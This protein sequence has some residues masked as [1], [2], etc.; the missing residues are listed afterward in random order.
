ME[1]E[2]VGVPE[3]EHEP[4]ARDLP[5]KCDAPEDG[6]GQ[7]LVEVPENTFRLEETKTVVMSFAKSAQSIGDDGTKVTL[8]QRDIWATF[9]RE[10]TEMLVTK[11]GRKMFPVVSISVSGLEPSEVYSIAID[12]IPGPHK[13]KYDGCKWNVSRDAELHSHQKWYVHPDSPQLGGDWQR[14]WGIT[15]H[16]LKITHNHDHLHHH[17]YLVLNTMHKFQP[18][19]II[20]KS[21][22][23]TEKSCSYH[24]FPETEF[25][26][27]TAYQNRQITL[28][29]I[30]H[31]PFAKG[32][33]GSNAC[34]PLSGSHKTV[35][36]HSSTEDHDHSHPPTPASP[37]NG[38]LLLYDA[39][40]TTMSQGPDITSR[41]PS[42]MSSCYDSSGCHGNTPNAAT[43]YFRA[44][45]DHVRLPHHHTPATGHTPG[46]RLPPH[47]HTST[48]GHTPANDL[49]GHFK[50][51]L[52]PSVAP[53]LPRSLSS[54]P[55]FPLPV[56]S[57]H[58]PPSTS[59]ALKLQPLPPLWPHP[60][61]VWPG[62]LSLTWSHTDTHPMQCSCCPYVHRHEDP[63][64]LYCPP[65]PGN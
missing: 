41:P 43:L 16:K 23:G 65:H 63:A 9:H 51:Q 59:D 3:P 53:P 49:Y 58:L 47:H 48:T 14:K 62:A 2:A 64:S 33:R 45:S 12:F 34:M 36:S 44:Y 15:F 5:C 22:G 6:S 50:L 56:N 26:T 13:Y 61:P 20:I 10:T 31:N 11:A 8:Y 40:N 39:P 60:L 28:M 55:P 35:T 19:V 52:P 32:F 29:K 18:R 30:E 1:L 57:G 38:P 27:V 7:A 46:N 4:K 25:M 37:S 42:S 21:T 54:P 24:I 17:G